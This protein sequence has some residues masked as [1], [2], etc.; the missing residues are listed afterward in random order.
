M[1]VS[2]LSILQTLLI[3]ICQVSLTY[4]QDDQSDVALCSVFLEDHL[5]SHMKK[6]LRD[7]AGRPLL[8][9]YSND[10]TSFLVRSRA[11]A[12]APSD[13]PSI[14]RRGKKLQEFLCQRATLKSKTMGQTRMSM[15]Q[16]P[17][18]PLDRG[19]KADNIIVSSFQF[20]THPRLQG[21]LGILMTHTV[22]DRALQKPLAR[23]FRQHRNLY[24]EQHDMFENDFD[25]LHLNSSDWLTQVGCGL[26][27]AGG[28]L[29]WALAPHS[30]DGLLEDMFISVES[31]RNTFIGI[32]SHLRIFLMGSVVYDRIDIDDELEAMLW[33]AMGVS[34][35]FLSDFVA[36]A[37]HWLDGMLHVRASLEGDAN[38]FELISTIWAYAMRWRK[39][40]ETR[41]NTVGASTRNVLRT[42]LL[43]LDRLVEITRA[44]PTITDYH[45]HGWVRCSDRVRVYQC[46][47][48][49]ACYPIEAVI[50]IMMADD[51]VCRQL[52]EIIAAMEDE[53]RYLESLP[54]IFWS[55]IADATRGTC[56]ASRLRNYTLHAAHTACGYFSRL[57]IWQYHQP[58]WVIGKG[59]VQDNF[60]ALLAGDRRPA[61]PTTDSI[62]TCIEIG[63]LL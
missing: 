1:T 15:L 47:A 63:C 30:A 21:H 14:Q 34:T 28:G 8:Y 18:V 44:D 50:L 58:P 29:R 62:R 51:R 2:P 41:W 45:L 36:V 9:S 59:N 4:S 7:S 24:Y 22:F 57:T 55:R 37:P 26:H 12:P 60:D 43:G 40:S 17:P 54:I 31:L 42:I 46:V 13:H 23:R 3:R 56:S 16:R 61:D 6:H 33:S 53:L 25:K 19:K 32:Y 39:F 11:N 52:D 49:M 27:D 48:A 20:W 10:A 35:D 38:N 5:D